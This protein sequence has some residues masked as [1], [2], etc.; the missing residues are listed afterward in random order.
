MRTIGTSSPPWRRSY[1][2]HILPV[3]VPRS[4]RRPEISNV[5]FNLRLEF[6]SIRGQLLHKSP[7]PTLDVALSELIA[8]EIRL[9][10]L[11]SSRSAEP[12]TVLAAFGSRSSCHKGQ[13]FASRDSSSR[14]AFGQSIGCRYC[15]AWGHM[16]KDYAKK[17]Q[18]DLRRQQS[19]SAAAATPS[20]GSNT[21]EM[22]DD[23]AATP[24]PA[25]VPSAH[26]PSVSLAQLMQILKVSQLG[27]F[28]PSTIHATT[29]L[30]TSADRTGISGPSWILDSGAS[31]HASCSPLQK[32]L[33]IFTA[34]GSP[35][36]VSHHGAI[37]RFF[38][39]SVL[40]IP[41]LSMNFFFC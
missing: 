23:V 20:A 13:P 16:L 22:F 7:L 24:A 35:L 10:V 11:G 27:G 4:S 40:H 37:G 1:V 2:L 14:H 39:L 17:K 12:A 41:K 29:A 32:P 8:E 31:I 3:A 36:S 33:Q 38:V 28:T 6:E 15:H 34:Y 5:Y 18:A 30:S 21:I 25:V 9:R 26:G 19:A